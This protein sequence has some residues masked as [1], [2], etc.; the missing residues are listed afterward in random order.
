VSRAAALHHEL[1]ALHGRMAEVHAEIAACAAE[2]EA[3]GV[4]NVR[5]LPARPKSRQRA[6]LVRVPDGPPISELAQKRA[7]AALRRHGYRPRTT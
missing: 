4:D 6:P 2:D 5:S 1:A 3:P 7:D